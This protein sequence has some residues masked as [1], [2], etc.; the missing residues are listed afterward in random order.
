MESKKCKGCLSLKSDRVN[1]IVCNV[2]ETQ[3]EVIR[4]VMIE[5]NWQLCYCGN[6]A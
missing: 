5:L 4:Q 6:L 2:T 1:K 3:Y